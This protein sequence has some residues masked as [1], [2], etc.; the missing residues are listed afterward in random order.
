[1][2]PTKVRRD[3]QQSAAPCRP[4]PLR[5]VAYFAVARFWLGLP[6]SASHL[7][8]TLALMRQIVDSGGAIWCP[9]ACGKNWPRS[10]AGAPSR[11]PGAARLRSRRNCARVGPLW[12]VPS[13]QST[14]LRWIQGRTLLLVLNRA[15]ALGAPLEVR[16]ACPTHDLGKGTTAPELLPR[17]RA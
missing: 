15:A 3:L 6:T 14:T 17:H 4:L 13:V 10:D 5:P 1:M 12:S 9:S 11:M 2:G 8:R 16:F 7:K